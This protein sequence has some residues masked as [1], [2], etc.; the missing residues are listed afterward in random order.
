MPALDQGARSRRCYPQMREAA[1]GHAEASMQ[2]EAAPLATYGLVAD[3]TRMGEYSPECFRCLW[4]DGDGP[5]VGARFRG[6]NKFGVVRWSR[7]CE[8]VAAEPG[9]E[10]AFRT[11]PL[12]PYADSTTWRYTFQPADAGTWVTESYEIT[13]LPRWMQLVEVISGRPKLLPQ[14]MHRT[15]G[16]IKA[17][18]ERTLAPGG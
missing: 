17:A 14:A 18:A 11:L 15:L 6:T 2:I 8:V 5:R 10:L 7:V 1:C 12:F 13:K 3:V 4:L 16:R 9:R